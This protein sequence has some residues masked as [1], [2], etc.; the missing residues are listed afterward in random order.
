M[1][2]HAHLTEIDGVKLPRIRRG[3]RKPEPEIGPGPYSKPVQLPDGRKFDSIA[4]AS[5][6]T[7]RHVA[8]L[9]KFVIGAKK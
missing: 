9:R 1:N 2:I 6:E 8:D 4:A 5:R 7:G 3:Y